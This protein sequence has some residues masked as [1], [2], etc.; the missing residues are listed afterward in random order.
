MSYCFDRPKQIPAM[1]GNGNQ[2]QTPESLLATLG[3]IFASDN[4]KK[5]DP[6]GVLE[7]HSKFLMGTVGN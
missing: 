3:Q 2:T 4:V 7:K 6:Y 1:L 5:S